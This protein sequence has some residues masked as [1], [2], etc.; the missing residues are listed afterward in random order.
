MLAHGDCTVLRWLVQFVAPEVTEEQ[1]LFSQLLCL[2]LL[3]LQECGGF[4]EEHGT[5]WNECHLR[6]C[7]TL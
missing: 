1:L 3:T 5:F 4:T 6:L 7:V 2:A